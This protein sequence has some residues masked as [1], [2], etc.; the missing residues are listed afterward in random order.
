MIFGGDE[1]KYFE[2]AVDVAVGDFKSDHGGT[3]N[4]KQ[5]ETAF[6]QRL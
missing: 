4:S 6:E 3:F 5:G 1:V 2:E